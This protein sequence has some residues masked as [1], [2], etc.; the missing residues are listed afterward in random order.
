MCHVIDM[1]VHMYVWIV[2][3]IILK[4]MGLGAAPRNVVSRTVFK[5]GGAFAPP[6]PGKISVYSPGEVVL[7]SEVTNLL[8]WEVEI[9]GD[10]SVSF[11]VVCACLH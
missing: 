9:F 3:L 7:F 2:K 8:L 1:C 11:V 4:G 5:G 10:Y 6:P